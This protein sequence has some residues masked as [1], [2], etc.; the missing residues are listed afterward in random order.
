MARPV[1]SVRLQKIRH[2]SAES[3][4]DQ[5]ATEEPLELRVRGPSLAS[6]PISVT[7]RTPGHDAELAVGFLVTE[8]LVR[9]RAD[10]DDAGSESAISVGPSNVV[11]VAL[12]R[13]LDLARFQRNFYAASSCGICGKTSLDHL[14]AGAELLGPGLVVSRS[15][16]LGLSERLRDAQAIFAATGGLHATGAFDP[17]GELLLLRE[18]I[19]RHNAMDKV[20]GRFFLDGRLPLADTILLAS[21]RLSFELVQKAA[22]AGVPILCAISAPSS[23]A[24][25]AAERLGMTLVAFL[26]DDAFNVYSC[27][28]RIDLGDRSG[29]RSH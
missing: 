1:S 3:C 21:G 15:V 12:R 17:R 5:L 27:P 26:R 29:A 18:D 16:L 10:L 14:D 28:E 23:L 9:E 11:T 6:T 24:V 25:R 20:I 7:M 19:G 8:G 13:D 22:M 2:S 4:D